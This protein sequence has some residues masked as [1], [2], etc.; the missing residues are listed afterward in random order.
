MLIA[1]SLFSC[2][3]EKPVSEEDNTVKIVNTEDFKYLAEQFADLKILRYNAPG[4]DE[5]SLKQKTLLYYLTEAAYWGRE[6]IYDQ[7]YKYNLAIKRT[8]EA[9][10]EHYTGDKESADYQLFKVYTKRVWFSNGIHHHYSTDKFVPEFSEAYFEELVKNSTGAEFP[11]QEG[12]TIDDFIAKLKPIIFDKS[13]DNKRVNLN[14]EVDMV[15]GSANNMYEGVTQKE[16]EAFYDKLIDKTSKEPISYGLNSK[17]VKKDGK[18]IE[19]TYKLGGMY[20]AA[21]EKIVF[22]L[23][24]AATVAESDAQR[25]TIEKLIKFY[26]TGDLKTFDDYS[27]AWVK[28]T[29]PL[30]DFTNGF[31]EVYGDALGFRGAW[32]SVVYIKDVETTKKFGALSGEAAWFEKNSPIMEAHKKTNPQGISYKVITV[33]S[34]AGDNSPST[35]IGV[36]LPNANW[37][38]AAYGSKSVSLGNIEHAY[39]EGSKSSGMLQ[40]FFL[41]EQ[42]QRIKKYGTLSGKLHTGLHEVIGHGSGKINDGVGTPKETLKN[43]ASTLEEARADLVALYYIIDNH[44]VEMNLTNT[45]DVGKAEYDSYIV[46]GLIRQLVRLEEGAVIE[47]AHMRN[48]QLIAKWCYEKGEKDKVIER[49]VVDGKTFFVVNDY[50]KLR[51]LFG[52]LL[53]EVQRIKSEGDYAAG[54]NLVE[55]YGVQVDEELHT[56]ALARFKKLNVAAYGGF[57]NPIL[58]PKMDGDKIIDVEIQYPEDFTEQMMYYAKK[59]KVL[60]TYN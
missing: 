55:T 29:A 11:L 7:N 8:L 15:V 27:V 23:K 22:W 10:I 20:G 50:E 39:T 13:I 41:P 54:K 37:I 34:E 52:E 17:L 47:E 9:I 28:D 1:F 35:P 44:L 21:I 16:V 18:I 58:V 19:Q 45:T 26:E 43:Y 32:Q 53:R 49:K 3:N 4:F 2:G 38:R 33:I 59:Y 48:R 57:I 6:I 5:L 31:I 46:N 40:E 51:E 14:P 60:P 12:E 36:N 25:E 24:K 56:E 30:V 42:I